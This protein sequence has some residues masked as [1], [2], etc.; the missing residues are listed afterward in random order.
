M[1]KDW[2]GVKLLRFY[3]FFVCYYFS[4]EWSACGGVWIGGG[5]VFAMIWCCGVFV[6]CLLFVV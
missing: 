6:C 3:R 5:D 4:F 1:R 2:D